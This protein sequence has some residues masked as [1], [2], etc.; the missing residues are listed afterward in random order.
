MAFPLLKVVGLLVRLASRPLSRLMMLLLKKQRLAYTIF[1]RM[2]ERANEFEAYLDFKAANPDKSFK[3]D[4][5]QVQPIEQE[6]SFHKG[7]EYFVEMSV[8]YGL[9]GFLS[10]Y[11]LRR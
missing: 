2:G 1:V 4:L 3:R 7:V 11:E 6:D 9:I 10:V 5:L 8:F